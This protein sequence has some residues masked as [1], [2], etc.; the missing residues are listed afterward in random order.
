MSDRLWRLIVTGLG[1]LVFWGVHRILVPGVDRY[2]LWEMYDLGSG[3]FSIGVMALAPWV[4]AFVVVELA[5]LVVPAWRRLRVVGADRSRVDLAVRVAWFAICLTQAYGMAVGLEQMRV[6][7]LSVVIE[8]GWLWRIVFVFT[9]TGASALVGWTAMQMGRLGLGALFVWFVGA[10]LF[11]ELLT[12]GPVVSHMD[13]LTLDDVLPVAISVAVVSVATFWLVN[14]RGKTGMWLSTAGIV[15]FSFGLNGLL[16]LALM[17]PGLWS[18]TGLA[19]TGLAILGTT[20][21]LGLLQSQPEATFGEQVADSKGFE[22]DRWRAVAAGVAFS[23][24]IC[25]VWWTSTDADTPLY[26]NP[27]TVVVA[28]VLVWDVVAEWRARAGRSLVVAASV[29][30]VR[31]VQVTLDALESAGID[32]HI[33]GVR[34]RQLT[35]FLAPWAAMDVLVAPTDAVRTQEVLTASF[36]GAA[37]RQSMPSS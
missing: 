36:G 29:H 21:I 33:R 14:A 25:A 1:L 34:L 13:V 7:Y 12:L 2:L 37:V 4:T 20:V 22:R 35:H 11:V 17:A 26:L 32:A 19:A 24:V 5:L 31:D 18:Y 3:M 23:A 16:F 8:P 27:G 15:P 9:M 10:E 28:L 30:R 6:G